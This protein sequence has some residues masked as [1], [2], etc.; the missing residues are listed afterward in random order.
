ML[1]KLLQ[2]YTTDTTR[3]YNTPASKQLPDRDE[4]SPE[5]EDPKAFRSP[6]MALMYMARLT[7]PGIM[8][9]VS[10][11]AT[12]AAKPTQESMGKLNRLWGYLKKTK[13][14]GIKFKKGDKKLKVHVDA[15][16]G[17]HP[18]G[19][20]HGGIIITYGSAPI[21]TR[22]WKI[23]MITRSSSETELVALEEASTFPSWIT[24]LLG[25]LNLLEKDHLPVVYQDNKSTMLLAVN[26][27]SF[28]R[29]KHLIIKRSFAKQGIRNKDFR[30]CYLPTDKMLT[31]GHTKS[32]TGPRHER[33]V[34]ELGM[35]VIR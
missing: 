18:E 34:K 32:I 33:F 17:L 22:S 25:D 15:S 7:R 11:L 31:D 35:N 19:E 21:F 30:I 26:G 6:V 8:H 24:H 2:K 10:V 13:D 29:T 12:N 23:K 5:I 1:Q 20:G 9:T 3:E 14:L 27:G 16:H 4:S 28:G